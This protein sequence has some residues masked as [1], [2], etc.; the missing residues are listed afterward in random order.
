MTPILVDSCIVIDL[1]AESSGWYQWSL[2]RLSELSATRPLAINPIIYAEISSAYDTP[3]DVE[4]ALAPFGLMRMSLPWESAFLAGTAYRIYRQRGGNRRSPLP[5]FYIGAHAMTSGM[6]LLTRDE[7]R[8][9]SY[10]PRLQM[11]TPTVV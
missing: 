10:F 9:R 8:Y 7:A 1:L 6:P 2:G 3:A 11:I 4:R 5:D